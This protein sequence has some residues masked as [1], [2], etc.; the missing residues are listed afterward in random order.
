MNMYKIEIKSMIK[1]FLI[2]I[3]VLIALLAFVMA[4]FPSMASSGMSEIIQTKMDAIPSSML[5]AFG[6]TTLDF[7]DILQYF[8]YVCQYILVGTCIY[9]GI[10]GANS[11]IKE[12]S[13]GI[14]E[15]L[16]AQPISRTKIV[17]VKI[18]ATITM[19]FIMDIILFGATA[20]SFEIFKPDNY[21]YMRDLIMVYS[22]MFMA[23]LVFL[24]IGF[25]I[26]TLLKKASGAT[27]AM[28]GI[29]FTTYML[30]MF[31]KMVEKLEWMKYLSP[32]DYVM[33]SEILKAGGVIESK[34]ISIC[35]II[36][37][38][39]ICATFYKYKNKDL[40]I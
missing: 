2:W 4:F 5:A 27:S 26:S 8:A 6:I 7:G 32:S 17:T 29:F 21:Q 9:S 38:L 40:Q 13:E 31:S 36:I 3:V 10:L 11:L 16:Y 34:Y 1:S 33:P 37:I 14:I 25:L 19:T 12:E 15:F 24:S 28:L 35:L 22:G 20:I 18:L 30:G 23:Q 39:S